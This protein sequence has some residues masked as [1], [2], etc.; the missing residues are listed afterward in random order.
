M[1]IAIFMLD[2]R[3]G[4]MFN[5]RRQSQD[6]QVIRKILDLAKGK[7]IRM[8]PYTASMFAE[9][10]S[11]AKI[12]SSIHFYKKAAESDFCIFE[13]SYLIDIDQVNKLIIFW[14][15]RNYPGDVFWNVDLKNGTW[16]RQMTEEFPGTSHE[17]ITMEIYIKGIKDA[18]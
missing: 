4:M 3:K 13:E 18:K 2:D 10:K 7:I 15:N 1:M 17:K 12:I 11:E 5:K 8:S 14:W 9:Q 6:S 16:F